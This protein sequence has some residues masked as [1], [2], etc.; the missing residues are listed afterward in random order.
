MDAPYH[1][2]QM[3]AWM[4]LKGLGNVC[5]ICDTGPMQI[6]RTVNMPTLDDQLEPEK[7]IDAHMAAI[8]LVCPNCGFI[9]LFDLVTMLGAQGQMLEDGEAFDTGK[10]PR[11]RGL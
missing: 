1:F 5:P 10:I 2:N 11:P 8:P 6:R 4:Q 7:N 3:I 9:E